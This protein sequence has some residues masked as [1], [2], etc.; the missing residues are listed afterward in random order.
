MGLKLSRGTKKTGSGPKLSKSDI[1]DVLRNSRRRRI[2]E[3]LET[4]GR[5]VTVRELAEHIAETESNQSPPPKNIR[6]SAYVSLHQT[7]L[8]KLDDLGIVDYDSTRKEICLTKRATDVQAYMDIGR[9][10]R[11]DWSQFYF[12]V[13]ALALLTSVGH[14]I[15]IPVLTEVSERGVA[16]FYFLVF[17]LF[18]SYHL[19]SQRNESPVP[20]GE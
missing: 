6:Q 20:F 15:G 5:T 4:A 1:H 9:E 12:G 8:P 16:N 19:W 7:H 2:M 3:R 11:H 13:G 17:T 18:A 14:A 10:N